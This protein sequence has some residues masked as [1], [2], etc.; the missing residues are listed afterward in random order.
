MRALFNDCSSLKSLPDISNWNTKNVKD[1][2]HMFEKCSSLESLPDI[3][4]W[5]TK[6]VID[7]SCMF[8]ECKSL[9]SLPDISKWNTENIKEIQNQKLNYEEYKLINIPKK[10]KYSIKD[11]LPHCHFWSQQNGKIIK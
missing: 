4:N 7:M 1:M 2:S 11:F 8:N 9:I 5:N 10:L 3:S 6:N